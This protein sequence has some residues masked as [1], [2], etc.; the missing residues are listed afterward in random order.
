MPRVLLVVTSASPV[1]YKTGE[2]TGVFWSEVAEPYDVF[3]DT[4][5]ECY[6]KSAR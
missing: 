4:R 1:L 3:C 2:R 6:P 5:L